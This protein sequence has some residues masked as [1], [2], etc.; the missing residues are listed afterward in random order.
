M[1]H[2]AAVFCICVTPMYQLGVNPA[3]SVVAAGLPAEESTQ[4][5]WAVFSSA[6]RM[7]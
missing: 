7:R 3:K 4:Y 5:G 6:D 1:A 2:F